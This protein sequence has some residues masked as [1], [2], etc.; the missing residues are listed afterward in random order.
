MRNL[1]SLSLLRGN[2]MGCHL[3]QQATQGEIYIQ[4]TIFGRELMQGELF[5]ELL[6]A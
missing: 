1:A 4:V 2:E 5:L 6:C 3:T